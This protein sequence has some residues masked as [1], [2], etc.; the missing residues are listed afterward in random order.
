MHDQLTGL[1]L[2]AA[3]NLI[4]LRIAYQLGA[5]LIVL[6]AMCTAFARRNNLHGIA[7]SR[8]P[9]AFLIRDILARARV[10]ETLSPFFLTMRTSNRDS[11]TKPKFMTWLDGQIKNLPLQLPVS[12][13]VRPTQRKNLNLTVRSTLLFAFLFLFGGPY[14]LSSRPAG[15]ASASN[16]HLYYIAAD[17]VQWNYAPGGR[18]V[19]GTPGPEVEG[20]ANATV[21]RKAVYREYTDAT[22]S[23]LK[24]R[25]AQ[26]QH[27]GILGPLIRAEVGDVVKIIFKNNTKFFCSMHPHGLEYAKDSEGAMYNDGGPA[28]SKTGAA[29]PPGQTYTY[30]WKVPERAGPGPMDGTSILWVYHSHFVE[31]RDMNTGLFGPILISAKGTTRA[32]GTPKDVDREFIAGF[33]VFDE[34]ESWYFEA[35]S[36]ARRKYTVGL[37]FTDPAFRQRYLFYSINGMIEGNLPVMTM[38]KGERVRWYLFANSNEDDVHTPHWHGQT[39]LFNHMRMDMVHLEPMMMV[40]ADMIPDSVGTWL[41]HCHVNEHIEGGMQTLFTVTP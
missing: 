14:V 23:T 19:I 12:S 8:G 21:F 29:V 22:F 2:G 15:N 18:N 38:K 11:R 16:T 37:K 35:N 20:S 41:F 30:I 6:I 34:T 13:P 4:R 25:P 27:L 26:W 3:G 36:Q 10:I 1:P 39:V 28:E 40:V 17:D 5:V 32:D 31:P 24:P 9:V 33:A 7:L